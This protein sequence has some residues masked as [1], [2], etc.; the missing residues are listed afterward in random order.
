MQFKKKNVNKKEEPKSE[1]SVTPE[2]VTD[3]DLSLSDDVSSFV[4]D[5]DLSLS[6]DDDLGASFVAPELDASDFET[7]EDDSA[8]WSSVDTELEAKEDYYI[9]DTEYDSASYNSEIPMPEPPML[10]DEEIVEHI[11]DDGEIVEETAE[12]KIETKATKEVAKENKNMTKTKMSLRDR[13]QAINEKN[14]AVLGAIDEAL[15]Q[16]AETQNCTSCVVTVDRVV[17]EGDFVMNYLNANALDVINV[18]ATGEESKLT[19]SWSWD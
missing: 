12:E 11:V 6:S 15:V 14:D 17:T 5:E 7:I 9:D 19:I 13:L 8:G 4:S 10:D 3:D 2:I 18:E 1:S 16:A